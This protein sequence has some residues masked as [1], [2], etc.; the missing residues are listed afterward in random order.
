VDAPVSTGSA[1]SG[2][3]V[4][5]LHEAAACDVELTGAKAATLARLLRAGFPVPD[6]FVVTVPALSSLTSA[7]PDPGAYPALPQPVRE[8]L[9]AFV[10]DRQDGCWAVRSSAVAEDAAGASFAGQYDS[11]L[12]VRGVAALEAAIVACWAS[13]RHPRVAGYRNQMGVTDRRFAV[14]V[15]RYVDADL[16]GVALGADPV[17]GDRGTV[18]VTAVR[19][20][21]AGLVDGSV[22]PDEWEVVAGEAR[23]R[24]PAER[25]L[26]AA[27]ARSI[28]AL[29]RRME[30]GR[31]PPKDLEWAMVDGELAVLQLRPMTGLPAQVAW[32]APLPGGWLRTIRLGE[33]LPEPVTPLCHTWLLDRIEERFRRCQ[34]TAAGF[35]A[36]A[37]MHVLV[38]GWYFH[39]PIGAGSQALLLTGLLR[40]PRLALATLLGRRRPEWSDRLMHA[41]LARQWRERILPRYRSA[42]GRAERRVEVAAPAELIDTVDGIA[43]LA[44]ECFWSLVLSGGAAWRAEDALARFHRR[45]LAHRV[46]APHQVLLQGL[47]DHRPPRHAVHS[48]D[49]IHPTA[50]ELPSGPAADDDT[51]SRHGRAVRE[52]LA[53]EAEC[54]RALGGCPRV[55]RRFGRLVEVAQRAAELRREHTDWF[56]AGWPMMRQ[57]IVRLGAAL[58]AAGLLDEPTDVFLLT[59]TEVEVGSRG[60]APGDLRALVTERRQSWERQRRLAPPASV[61]KLPFLLSKL[62]LPADVRQRRSADGATFHGVPASPGRATGPVRVLRSP[63]AI[64]SVR[65]GDVL[66]VSAALPALTAVFG[67]IRALCVDNGSVAAHAAIVAREY[68]IP[69]V[70]GLVDATA[71]LAD[72]RVVTV[73]G[74][75]GV[76]EPW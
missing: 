26:T 18:I 6:G 23:C 37:P 57:A 34:H 39:S 11:H 31:Q 64:H 60:G 49:W 21:G 8:S 29:L 42:I 72:G 56:T 25:I 63:T 73:D 4:V 20:V 52:R 59:R 69:A 30:A 65:A 12:N 58:C 19:G 16:A 14:L 62:L 13:A 54:R 28:A 66:V 7:G 44:G 47:S 53:A 35:R 70:M 15:Q 68:G 75:A 38:H 71:R 55:R 36:S 76:V 51:R 48:L 10:A 43:G 32:R 50:G 40:R 1:A 67:R 41:R 33:W 22:V 17:T 27:H 74:T 45:H 61:G 2:P 24:R 5:A 46:A 9:R 3:T